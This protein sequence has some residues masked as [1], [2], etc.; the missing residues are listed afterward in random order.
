MATG[1]VTWR[2]EGL[3]HHGLRPRHEGQRGALSWLEATSRGA[4]RGSIMATGR[5]T[6]GRVARGRV[7]A[8]V[9]VTQGSLVARL[10]KT[11]V[12][13]KMQW[14]PSSAALGESNH[15]LDATKRQPR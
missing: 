1:N 10:P 15:L 9:E 7:A 13:R 6:R 8:L 2:S 12:G 14:R 3:Y 5:V 4:A 11:G